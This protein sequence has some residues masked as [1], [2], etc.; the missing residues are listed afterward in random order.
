MKPPSPWMG[1]MMIA[2]TLLAPISFSMRV[3]AI[4]AISGPLRPRSRNGYDVGTR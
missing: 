2:A 1:S 4:C 3:M